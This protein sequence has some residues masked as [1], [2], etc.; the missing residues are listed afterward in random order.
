MRVY[1]ELRIIICLLIRVAKSRVY[2]TS[3]FLSCHFSVGQQ[4]HQFAD[5]SK[6][7]DFSIHARESKTMPDYCFQYHTDRI[8]KEHTSTKP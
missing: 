3:F 5:E 4:R 1:V 2:C 7:T 8:V 6:L